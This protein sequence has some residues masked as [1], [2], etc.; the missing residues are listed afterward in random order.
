[1]QTVT[2]V[3]PVRAGSTRIPNKNIVPFAGTTLLEH[4]IEVLKKVPEITKVLV[5]SDSREMLE[6]AKKHGAETH[7]RPAEYC[8]EKSL[9]FA[10]TVRLVCSET[11]GDHILWAPCT[12]PLIEPATFSDAIQVYLGKV[13]KGYDS[14]LAVEELKK[15]IW[16]KEK[17]LNYEL[18]EKQVPSQQLPDW[19]AVVCGL[20]IISREKAIKWKYVYGGKMYQYVVDHITAVDIDEPV[21]LIIAETL[22]KYKNFDNIKRPIRGG[23]METI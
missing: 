4:K 21:D 14:L 23:G 5:T 20:S 19:Y 18:G 13:Q 3:I 17:P 16:D 10:E 2:A 12:S 22:F 6:I 7:V 1:M 9:P 15:F 8:D 11:D